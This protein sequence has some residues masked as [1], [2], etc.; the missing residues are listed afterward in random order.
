MG[1]RRLIKGWAGVLMAV[2]LVGGCA[3]KPALEKT[4]EFI[5]DSTITTKV[6]ARLI[7]DPAVSALAINVD[8][9][10]GVVSLTGIVGSERER[11]RAIDL[12]QAVTGVT[13]VDARNV[14]VRR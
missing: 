3:T 13:R 9:T 2:L 4:G 10:R 5:D 6:K 1:F 8:T 12:A 11:Q 14:F 7:A